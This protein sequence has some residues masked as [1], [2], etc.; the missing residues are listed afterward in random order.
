MQKRVV[1]CAPVQSGVCVYLPAHPALFSRSP[2]LEVGYDLP[3]VGCAP[4]Q[5]GQLRRH[6][7]IRYDEWMEVIA[8]L[9]PSPHA[10][11]HV[12]LLLP[13]QSTIPPPLPPRESLEL[14]SAQE[15]EA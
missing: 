7:H 13:V 1:G 15:S 10:A 6:L 12:L 11:T 2:C 8:T 3:D 9:P 4:L 14:R 5:K